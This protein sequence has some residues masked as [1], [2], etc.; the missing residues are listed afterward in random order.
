MFNARRFVFSILF[1]MGMA[2]IISAQ[3][4]RPKVEV[5]NGH[6]SPLMAKITYSSGATRNVMVLALSNVQGTETFTHSAKFRD[7]AE[8]EVDVWLDSIAAIRKA[9]DES[10]FIVLKSGNERRLRW[11]NFKDDYRVNVLVVANEDGGQEKINLARLEQ[12]QFLSVPRRDKANNAMY[13]QWNY[14]PFTG[15]KLPEK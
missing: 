6:V 1:L 5:K 12:V 10:A 7:E 8:S 15:E 11:W 13:D 9:N 4:N 2:S 3:P 14:S